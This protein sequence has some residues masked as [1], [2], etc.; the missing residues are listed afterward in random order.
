MRDFVE[1]PGAVIRQLPASGM[2]T[3]RGTQ[4]DPAFAAALADC[5]VEVPDQRCIQL[6]AAGQVAWMSPDE[7]LVL[8]TAEAATGLAQRLSAALAGQHHLLAE[9]SDARARFTITGP[10]ARITLAKLCPVDMNSVEQGRIRRTRLAQIAAAFWMTGPD[11]F[12]LFCFRSVADYA[13]TA[14][15]TSARHVGDITL[16]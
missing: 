7:L 13:R 8:C 6:C 11:A 14:L 10:G 9:V 12:E 2:I 3:L 1:Q 5:G 4:S 15:E 16:P